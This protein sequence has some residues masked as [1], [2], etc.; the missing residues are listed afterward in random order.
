M[1]I[2]SFILVLLIPVLLGCKLLPPDAGQSRPQAIE[3]GLVD[4]SA[5]SEVPGLPTSTVIRPKPRPGPVTAIAPEIAPVTA[6]ETTPVDSIISEPEAEKSSAQLKCERQGGNWGKA[7]ASS[8]RACI[9]RTRDSGK[10]C[11]KQSDC[12]SVC[13]ARSGTCAPVKPLFGCNEIL[14]NDGRRVTLCV[15]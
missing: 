7:G 13:L 12:D 2:A 15:E 5:E 11:R 4:P 10:Q 3:A 1:R 6:P 14:Q 8:A 9:K